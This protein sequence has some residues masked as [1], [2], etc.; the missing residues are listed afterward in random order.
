MTRTQ[1]LD[2]D[3]A[4]AFGERM[5]GA[6]NDASLVVMTSLGHRTGLFDAM[7]ELAPSTSAAIAQAA[8]LEERY[9]REWLGAMVTGGVVEYDPAAQTYALPPEHAACLTRAAGSDNLGILA[10]YLP[11]IAGVED[12]VAECFRHGGGVPYSSYPRLQEVLREDTGA[13]VDAALIDTTLPLVAGLVDRLHEGIAVADVGCGA[14]HA[15][16]VMAL[17]FPNSRFV[18]YDLSEQGVEMA[19]GEAERLGL[20]N[21]RFEIRDLAALDE[22]GAFDLITAFDVI[23]DQAKPAEVLARIAA[24]LRPGGTF[25]MVDIAASS[26]LED[27][28]DHPLGPTLY[29]LS[30]MHCMTVSLASDGAGLGT[31]WGEQKALEMLGEAG[32]DPV[33]VRRIEGD[34]F[35]N[36]YVA[37]RS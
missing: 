37:Q 25:L 11:L 14:G 9:V 1:A 6:V 29:A 31:V 35:N 3:K 22:R 10:S 17:A 13:V 28:V 23:H 19:R 36:Y 21:A 34:V 30:T 18:G 26:H 32:F 33:Q 5:V 27:N 7:A 4:E 24:A 12:E 8:E 20:E 15:I 2:P 16:N